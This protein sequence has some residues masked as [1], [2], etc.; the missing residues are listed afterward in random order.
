MGRH[1]PQSGSLPM[2]GEGG[3]PQ[4]GNPQM[5][6][7]DLAHGF[8]AEWAK[9]PVRDHL[10]LFDFAYDSRAGMG[11]DDAGIYDMVAGRAFTDL[12][13]SVVIDGVIE[14]PFVWLNI[15]SQYYYFGGYA[16]CILNKLIDN[17][18]DA[19]LID[20]SF[21][22]Y[23][24]SKIGYFVRV[25]VKELNLPRARLLI[26]FLDV[27]HSYDLISDEDWTLNMRPV[28]AYVEM[29]CPS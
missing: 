19:S 8:D 27:C 6:L 1:D 17:P 28:S 26:H 18:A 16:M 7:A 14:S 15:D 3:R 24:V 23:M 2:T 25:P 5:N 11:P 29:H 10:D 4:T 12:D 9:I 20:A 13:C 21:M 22:F